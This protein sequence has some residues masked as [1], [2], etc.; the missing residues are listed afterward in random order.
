[1]KRLSPVLLLTILAGSLFGTAAPSAG[2]G[3]PTLRMFPRLV[4]F[5]GGLMKDQRRYLTDHEEVMR[6]FEAVS[7]SP[8]AALDGP[9]IR[10]RPYIEVALYW[11]NPHWEPY[12]ATPSSLN[13][14]PLPSVAPWSLPPLGSDQSR[15]VQPARLY[16]GTADTKPAFD[17]APGEANYSGLRSIGSVG[18]EILRRH[19]IQAQH[20]SPIIG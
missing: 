12:I 3:A 11:Y 20:P 17:H 18:L 6:F 9:A 7:V 8:S 19:E 10:R 1:V 2:S 4:L 5:Y 16:L 13:D 14:L 15:F